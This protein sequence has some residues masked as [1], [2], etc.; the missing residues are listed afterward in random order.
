MAEG[1]FTMKT[2]YIKE[3][4]PTEIAWHELTQWRRIKELKATHPEIYK[5]WA[6]ANKIP[7]HIIKEMEE[8]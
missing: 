6:A 7:Y 8:N 4:I 3:P 5:R 1:G 2:I